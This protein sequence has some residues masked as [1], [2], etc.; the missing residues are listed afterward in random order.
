MKVKIFMMIKHYLKYKIN[1][2]TLSRK[3]KTFNNNGKNLCKSIQII[4]LSSQI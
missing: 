4:K 1:W 3:N 2:K